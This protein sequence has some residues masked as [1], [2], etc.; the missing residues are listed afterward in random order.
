MHPR[1]STRLFG[2]ISRLSLR[3]PLILL[4]CLLLANCAQP[5]R[6][7][8]QGYAPALTPRSGYEVRFTV[9]RLKDHSPILAMTV[10][11]TLGQR[12]VVRTSSK[13]AKEDTPA[14]PEF[15]AQLSRT[16]TAGV[17]QLVTKVAIREASR[18]KKGKLKITK[19]NEG[20]LLPLR[21]GEEN[22]ASPA[23]DPIQINVRVDRR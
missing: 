21:L 6:R 8:E 23:G 11:L 12:A 17:F 2:L 13:V 1:A 10:P 9:T 15:A 3:W 20:A 18:N 22:L 14:L 16:K 7:N 5:P 4:G 19:R